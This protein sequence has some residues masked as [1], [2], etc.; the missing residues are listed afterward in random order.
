MSNERKSALPL[1]QLDKASRAR[2]EHLL[3]TEPAALSQGD[4]DFLHGRRD[5]LTE[6]QRNDY[7]VEVENEDEGDQY[8]AMNAAQL[9]DEL[10]ARGLTVGGKV[11][12]LRDRLRAD[13]A[14]EE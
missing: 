9:K 6:D 10:Q 4:R 2:I 12:E 5:Y 8:D 7:L 1:A 11:A 3:G 14:D 13:D